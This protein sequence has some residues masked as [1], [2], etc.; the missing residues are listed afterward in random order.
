MVQ[1][2]ADTEKL[3]QV[4]HE[5]DGQPCEEQIPS[6]SLILLAAGRLP[7]CPHLVEVHVR[8]REKEARTSM[9]GVTVT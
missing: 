6:D 1:E 5:E 9:T 3:R 2:Q 8:R 4:M 7:R